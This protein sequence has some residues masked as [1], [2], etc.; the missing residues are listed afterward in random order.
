MTIATDYTNWQVHLPAPD[1]R[2]NRCSPNLLALADELGKRWGMTDLGCYGWR[3]IRAGTAPS[4]HGFGAAIDR[5]YDLAGRA[6]AL[7]EILPYLIDN[8]D[9]LHI[10][11]I[12]DYLGCRIWHADRQAWKAQKPNPFNGM[13]QSWASYFH[14]ETS[15]AGWGDAAPI[16][17]RRNDSGPVIIIPDPT[18]IPHPGG[19]FMHTPCSLGDSGEAVYT[20]QL[21]LR[22][23]AGNTIIV[24]DGEFGTVTEQGVEMFQNWYGLTADGQVGP[25]TWAKMDEVVNA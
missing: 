22:K 16:P 9:E 13:G 6:R 25:K 21:I 11:A 7:S 14:I 5:R 2:Y 10:S 17:N 4:S 1:T 19:T 24:C 15:L 20:V 18:P 8:S 12:H 23:L 3:P